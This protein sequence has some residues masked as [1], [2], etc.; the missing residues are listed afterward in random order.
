MAQQLSL[1][2]R[3][4]WVVTHVEALPN[5]R[6]RVRFIDGL[7]GTVD[8]A[9]RVRAKKAGVFAA[10]SDPARF[11]QVYIEAGA[12]TWPGEIDLAPDSMHAVIKQRGERKLK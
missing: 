12:V 8:M 9:A 3:L 10:L 7:E 5:F 4:P 6:L 11:N 1:Q 2:A